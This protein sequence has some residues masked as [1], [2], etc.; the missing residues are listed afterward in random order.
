MALTAPPAPIAIEMVA[1]PNPDAA[2]IRALVDACSLAAG[3]GACVVGAMPDDAPP[4]ATAIVTFTGGVAGVRVEVVGSA[5]EATRAARTVTFRA[6]DPIAE[7]F[8]AAGLIVAGLVLGTDAGPPDEAAERS[9]PSPALPPANTDET[10]RVPVA[11]VHVSAG[12]GEGGGRPWWQGEMGGDFAIGGALFASI[13]GLYARTMSRDGQG[14]EDQRSSLA[15]GL[16]GALSLFRDRLQLRVRAQGAVVEVRADIVQPG[17]GRQGAG[18][19]TLPGAGG[20]LE[21]IA[22][23]GRNLG[24]FVRDRF[25]FW[26]SGTR[27]RVDGGSVET[28]GSWLDAA[29]VGLNVRLP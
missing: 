9:V 18:D 29:S 3:G 28:I 20:E 2:E 7:R 10:A 14:I 17:T 13:A 22:P 12:A 1:D 4:R 19:R 23:L 8:R 21:L 5:G 11:M 24:V 6:E 27:L 16:G 15:V 25:D 26:G